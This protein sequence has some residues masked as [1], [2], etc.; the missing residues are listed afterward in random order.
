MAIGVAEALVQDGEIRPDTLCAAWSRNYTPGRPYGATRLVLEAIQ[1]G[2]D[3]Q[4]VARTLFPGGSYG[5]GAAMRVAPVGLFFHDDFDLVWRQAELS[6]LPTH[7]HPLGV[8][9]AQLVALAVALAVVGQS[10]DRDL[11]FDELLRRCRTAEYRARL[12][13]A[14]EVN[15]TAELLSLGNSVRALDSA[16]TAI[17]CFALFPDSCLEAVSAA[18]LLGGDTDT[19]AAMA[20]AIAGARGGI[21]SLPVRILAQLDDGIRGRTY[22]STL[23]RRLYDVSAAR[24]EIAKRK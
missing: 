22:V 2:G 19:I 17:T 9:G 5:N 1:R 23:A 12:M 20:G 18:I 8:E 7:A 10:F 15:G 14:R 24:N 6:A 13:A 11:F 4:T 16:V 3:Y 21:R